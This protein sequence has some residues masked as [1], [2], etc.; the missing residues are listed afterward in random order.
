MFVRV[1]LNMAKKIALTLVFLLFLGLAGAAGYFYKSYQYEKDE[2]KNLCDQLSRQPAIKDSDLTKEASKSGEASKSAVIVAS[3]TAHA[4]TASWKIYSDANNYYTIKYPSD[5]KL[6]APDNATINFVKWGPTQKAQT[7]FYDGVSI[8]ITTGTF[9]AGETLEKLVNADIEQKQVQLG[10]DFKINKPLTAIIING[11]SGLTY[12][13][14]TAY[15]NTNYLYFAVGKNG[16]IA[17]SNNTRDPNNQGYKD[18]ANDIIGTL[19]I[20]N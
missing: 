11:A 2:N 7:E 1:V 19:Q 6:Q 12:D 8:T 17:I 16:F 5:V 4:I 20:T 3:P 14:E 10:S 13:G 9:T 15:G 18:L